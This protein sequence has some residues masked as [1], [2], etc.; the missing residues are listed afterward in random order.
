MTILLRLATGRFFEVGTNRRAGSK[1]LG[2]NFPAGLA[3][4]AKGAIQLNG[5]TSKAKRSLV[6]FWAVH[7]PNG[8]QKTC[9]R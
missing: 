7:V 4:F 3:G 1:Q 2:R 5:P 6:D 9:H 8:N